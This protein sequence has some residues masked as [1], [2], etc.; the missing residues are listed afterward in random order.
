MGRPRVRRGYSLF[1]SRRN[2]WKT[3]AVCAISIIAGLVACFLILSSCQPFLDYFGP[4]QSGEQET[5]SQVV[6]RAPAVGVP[7]V[8]E[9]ELTPF[10][11]V[12]P[13]E[14]RAAFMPAEE[15][16]DEN[17]AYTY[18]NSLAR[19]GYNTV[20]FECKDSDGRI[21][22]ESRDTFVVQNGLMNPNGVGKLQLLVETAHQ[23]GLTAYAS[24]YAFED[25]LA[26]KY[27]FE[28]AIYH[29]N[30]PN[31]FWLDDELEEGGRSWLNPCSSAAQD[32]ICRIVDEVTL[33]GADGVLLEGAVFPTAYGSEYAGYGEDVTLEDRAD[34][35]A[36]FV[37][38][39]RLVARANEACLCL[40]VSASGALGLDTGAYGGANPLRFGEEYAVVDLSLEQFEKIVSDDL[41][42]E[43]PAA[44][45]AA[46]LDVLSG[47][48]NK[49]NETGVVLLCRLQYYL[50][51]SDLDAEAF[52]QA[53]SAAAE[54]T[55]FGLYYFEPNGLYG[56]D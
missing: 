36:S 7:P 27:A 30:Q 39:C 10:T 48:L 13:A 22:Y 52:R 56:R 5:S 41:A 31:V 25:H 42:V 47:K 11:P 23:F 44:D 51:R 45:P 34:Y 40:S 55:G 4:E 35:L 26:E 9:P 1:P 46:A 50:T 18:L 32:Y 53:Q 2:P 33:Y 28:M 38:R 16:A 43:D 29:V 14:I 37:N 6:S 12:E 49:A 20:V 17:R 8:S 21:C 19:Q 54:E 3:A 24:V 15:M